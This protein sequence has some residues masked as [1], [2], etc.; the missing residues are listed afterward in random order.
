MIKFS[1]LEFIDTSL[2]EANKA[3]YAGRKEKAIQA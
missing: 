2:Q 1:R 3:S